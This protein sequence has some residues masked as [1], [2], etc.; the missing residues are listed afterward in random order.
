[1]YRLSSTYLINGIVLIKLQRIKQALILELILIRFEA[2]TAEQSASD[3]RYFS[4]KS[5]RMSLFSECFVREQE[6][7]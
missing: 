7:G 6:D 4:K 5:S 3:E 2:V 1:M